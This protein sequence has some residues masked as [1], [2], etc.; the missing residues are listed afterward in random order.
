MTRCGGC[1]R[2]VAPCADSD[3]FCRRPGE[4]ECLKVQIARLE[5]QVEDERSKGA[6]LLQAQIE[7]GNKAWAQRQEELEWRLHERDE[8]RKM[9]EQQ[10]QDLVR[11]SGEIRS[12]SL[13]LKAAG[14]DQSCLDY[15]TD[16]EQE[17]SSARAALEKSKAQSLAAVEALVRAE[18]EVVRLR[19]SMLSARAL[20]DPDDP[21]SS[22]MENACE[23]IDE[24]L[25]IPGC[26]ACGMRPWASHA[27]F[28]AANSIGRFLRW[29][30]VPSDVVAELW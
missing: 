16:L 27:C 28:I 10:T 22:Y 17:S 30:L 14:H 19:V 21:D 13:F 6:R 12:L 25:G 7:R 2:E 9:V 5:Q 8:A 26:P 15:V 11:C 24:A 18:R 23:V 3:G 1:K 20:L 4:P 29:G